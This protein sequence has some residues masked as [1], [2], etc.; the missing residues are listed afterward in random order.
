MSSFPDGMPPV[1]LG[2]VSVEQVGA[3]ALMRYETTR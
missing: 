3:A 2:L 1:D